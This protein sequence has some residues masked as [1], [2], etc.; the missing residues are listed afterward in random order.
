MDT[1]FSVL[2]M[3]AFMGLIGL[4]VYDKFFLSKTRIRDYYNRHYPDRKIMAINWTMFEPGWFGSKASAYRVTYTESG[5]ANSQYAYVRT[6]LGAGVYE[7]K[8]R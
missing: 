6:G 2:P 1:F 4:M 3:L 5:N 8:D 7:T